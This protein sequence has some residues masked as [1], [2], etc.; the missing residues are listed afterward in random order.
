MIIVEIK[1]KTSLDSALKTLKNKFIKS[2]TVKD[3]NERKTFTKRSDKR[4]AKIRKAKY[5]ESL[6]SNKNS[7]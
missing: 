7:D 4:R 2:K 1:G 3:L 6:R 5:I